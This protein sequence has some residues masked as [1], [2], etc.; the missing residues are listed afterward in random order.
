MERKPKFLPGIKCP[1]C[2][3]RALIT[4]YRPPRGIDP[5][6]RQYR[7]RRCGLVIYKVIGAAAPKTPALTI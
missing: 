2:W 4:S 1:R 6:M 5:G 7:C 3:I